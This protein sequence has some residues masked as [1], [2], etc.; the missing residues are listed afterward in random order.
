MIHFIF[1]VWL[2]FHGQRGEAVPGGQGPR[3]HQAQVL[4]QVLGDHPLEQVLE[5]V[6]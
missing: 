6:L 3:Y 1:Q 5:Q 2:H 4:Q